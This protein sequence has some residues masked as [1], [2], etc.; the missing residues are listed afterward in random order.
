M[1]NARATI[2]TLP[3]GGVSADRRLRDRRVEKTGFL[4]G[5]GKRSQPNPATAATAKTPAKI[6][7]PAKPATGNDPA[8]ALI[9]QAEKLLKSGQANYAAGHLEAAR[10]DFDQ[11]FN[12]LVSSNLDIHSDERLEQEFSKI[13]ESVHD[14]ETGRPQ[15]GR[16]L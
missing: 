4:A 16:R 6:Q 9:A 2:L 7:V 11:A 14:L 1:S 15:A 13:V 3:A 5:A 8:D 12:L 10:A